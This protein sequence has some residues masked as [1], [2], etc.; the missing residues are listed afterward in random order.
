MALRRASAAVVLLALAVVP[1]C[2]AQKAPAP[3]PSSSVAPVS[4]APPPAQTLAPSQQRNERIRGMLYTAGCTSNSCVQ[5]Y[6]ACLDGYLTGEP[7]QFFRDHP[8]PP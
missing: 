7:C 6:F 4:S 5:A 8:P 3:A 1:G 2:A